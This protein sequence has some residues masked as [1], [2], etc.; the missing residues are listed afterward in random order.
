M[1]GKVKQI[2]LD[3]LHGQMPAT[4]DLLSVGI[5]L[6]GCVVG[7]I[8]FTKILKILL[9]KYEQSTLAILCGFMVGSL[10]SLW[11]FQEKNILMPA[12][13]TT[14]EIARY[15]NVAPADAQTALIAAAIALGSMIALLTIEYIAKKGS[16]PNS[17][18]T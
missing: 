14:K 4:S 13:E 12:T 15:I 16:K 5:F 17:S 3:I 8:G 1:S 9:A 18:L 11:P 6:C 2:A 7:I 10:R